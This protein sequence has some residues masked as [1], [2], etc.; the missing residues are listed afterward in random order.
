[1]GFS[2]HILHLYSTTNNSLNHLSEIVDV[3]YFSF[4]LVSQMK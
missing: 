1:M 4:V 2:R 3:K